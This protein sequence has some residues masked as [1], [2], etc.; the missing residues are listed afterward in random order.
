MTVS[1][2]TSLSTG[3]TLVL[4]VTFDSLWDR[5]ARNEH[6]QKSRAGRP[7]RLVINFNAWFAMGIQCMASGD[8]V[9]A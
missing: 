1:L 2:M 5:R 6:E 7:D 9:D 8:R 4:I 3:S